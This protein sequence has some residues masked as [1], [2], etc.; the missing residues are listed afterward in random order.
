MCPVLRRD[1]MR[2]KHSSHRECKLSG[3]SA[4]FLAASLIS[5]SA[6]VLAG[7][8]TLV[9][10]ET[11]KCPPIS[12]TP[13]GLAIIGGQ[14]FK[15]ADMGKKLTSLGV[16]KAAYIHVSV[17][18]DIPPSMEKNIGRA[19]AS[20]GYRRFVLVE[21]REVTVSTAADAATNSTGF[22]SA[23]TPATKK[24]SSSSKTRSTSR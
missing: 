1:T 16:P 10:P 4:T 17:Y 6:M 24:Q 20:A 15:V 19:L 21:P 23:P 5:M 12:I 11:V 13:T 18:K 7:C 8:A 9:S 22:V 3:R 14:K 2:V